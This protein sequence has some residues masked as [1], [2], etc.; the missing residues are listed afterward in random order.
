MLAG[1]TQLMPLM[2]EVSPLMDRGNRGVNG[3]EEGEETV[4]FRRDQMKGRDGSVRPGAR[5]RR[6]PRARGDATGGRRQ[7]EST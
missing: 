3:G 6:A 5:R 2:A 1:L 7:S 4:V